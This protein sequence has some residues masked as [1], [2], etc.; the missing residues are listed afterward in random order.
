MQFTQTLLQFDGKKRIPLTPVEKEW[1][2]KYIKHNI[3][4]QKAKSKAAGSGK[5]R[6]WWGESDRH[7]KAA[8]GEST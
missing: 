8:K 4:K 3:E 6:G 7:A 2:V 5:G 1:R